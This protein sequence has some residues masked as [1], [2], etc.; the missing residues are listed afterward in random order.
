MERYSCFMSVKNI[1][2]IQEELFNNRNKGFRN[3]SFK[4]LFFDL[5]YAIYD[6]DKTLINT[7]LST[8][9]YIIDNS[10]FNN[11]PFD[12]NNMEIFYYHLCSS[13]MEQVE[14]NKKKN[15]E[16]YIETINNYVKTISDVLNKYRN[17][18]YEEEKKNLK[19][20]LTIFFS[21]I[22]LDKE[23][24]YQISQ[25]AVILKEPLSDE[26]WKTII[27][28]EKLRFKTRFI[29]GSEEFDKL[30]LD[31]NIY[32]DINNF[33]YSNGKIEIPEECYLP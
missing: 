11:Q 24:N 18:D 22:S 21:I 33:K 20:F 32:C 9:R 15:F 4:K 14:I 12:L 19:K 16:E 23:N 28:A 8:I 6:N 3:I 13:F 5:L 1:K 26:E 7:K 27:E 31:K 25:V 29:N 30:I 2:K 17:E 10:L